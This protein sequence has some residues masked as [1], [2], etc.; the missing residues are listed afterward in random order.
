MSGQSSSAAERSAHVTRGAA[1]SAPAPSESTI[2]ER[3]NEA[4]QTVAELRVVAELRAQNERLRAA[5]RE[6]LPGNLGANRLIPDDALI[7]V[8]MTMGEIRRARAVLSEPSL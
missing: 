6:L 1:P 4:G 3:K 7:P 5:L 8:D 2:L